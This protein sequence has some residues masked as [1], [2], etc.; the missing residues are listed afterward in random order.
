MV[1]G[2]INSDTAKWCIAIVFVA[3]GVLFAVR[4]NTTRSIDNH[5]ELIQVRIESARRDAKL[6]AILKEMSR[7]S[8]YLDGWEP[9]NGQKTQSKAQSQAQGSS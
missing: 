6:D 7:I 8:N 3:G 1:K 5:K 4:Q 2:A 9:D